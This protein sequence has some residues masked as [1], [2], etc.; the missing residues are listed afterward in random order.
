MT[1]HGRR[2]RKRSGGFHPVS[3]DQSLVLGTLPDNSATIGNLT[4]DVVD[5]RYYCISMDITCSLR[6]LTVGEGPIN[7]G[8]MHGGM[9]GPELEE[10]IEHASMFARGNIAAQ[11]ITSRGRFIRR[12]GTFSG[13]TSHEVLAHGVVQRIPLGFPIEVL[14]TITAWVY[15]NSGAVLTTG[16]EVEYTGRLYGKYI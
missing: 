5:D 7:C 1:K 9:T 8:V 14:G 3:L 16:A 6:D 4:P 11:E 10:W 12:I 13:E 2:R 15:N